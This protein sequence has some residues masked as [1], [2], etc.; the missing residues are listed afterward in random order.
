MDL[1]KEKIYDDERPIHEVLSEFEIYLSRKLKASSVDVYMIG[2]KRFVKDGKKINE[3]QDYIDF[4]IEHTINKKSSYYYDVLMKFVN[5]INIRNDLKKLIISTMKLNGKKYPDVTKKTIIMAKRQRML[6]IDNLSSYKHQIIGLIQ[7]ETGVRA[8]DVLR[9][10]RGDITYTSDEGD[11]AMKF[12]FT[13]KGDKKKNVM[14]FNQDAIKK[15]Q[16]FIRTKFLHKDYYFLE[17]KYI[18]DK[19]NLLALQKRN[20]MLYWKD[21]RKVCERFGYNPSQFTS[22]DIRRNFAVEMLGVVDNNVAELQKVM[23]H[24]D[25]NTTIRYLRHSALETKDYMKK[26]NLLNRY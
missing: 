6:I 11:L 23:G 7:E 12:S 4:I 16:Q 24:K 26:R 22:H 3:P 2:I 9:L 21:L 19:N 8:G 18:R 20:Y 17:D 10:K 1:N 13:Q 25:I 15:I 5:W 14:I